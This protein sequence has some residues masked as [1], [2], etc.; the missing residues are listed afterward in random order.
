MAGEHDGRQAAK[1]SAME[2][3]KTG[4]KIASKERKAR[5]CTNM[6]QDRAVVSLAYADTYYC[7]T[8]AWR[9]LTIMILIKKYEL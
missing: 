4:R 2:P 8:A 9:R 7:G 6:I 3:G 5:L 1:M